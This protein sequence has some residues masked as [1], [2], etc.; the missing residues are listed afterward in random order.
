MYT[1][2]GWESAM[3]ALVTLLATRGIPLLLLCAATLGAQTDGNAITGF[4]PQAT[5]QQ[6]DLETQFDKILDRGDL[7]QWMHRIT[8]KPHHV[9]SPGSK[10]V[11]EFIA[12]LFKSWGY[13]TRID[14]Y[15][16]LF[17]TPKTRVV[18]MVAPTQYKAT[19]EE[20][21]VE[22]DATTKIREGSL[23][24]YNAYSG[25][26][27]V[28]GELVYVNYGI[29]D[30]YKKL[31][32]M[33]IDVKGKI[34]IAR[35]GGSWRGIKPKVA[36]ENGAIA[37]LIYSDPR[38][39]GYYAGDA[40]P[41]GGYRPRYGA[42]RGSVVDM[43]TYPGDPLTPGEAATDAARNPDPRMAATVM[44]IPV[45][46][47]SWGDAEPLLKALGGRVVPTSWRGALPFT[48]HVGPGPAKVHMKLEFDW[49][50]VP[51]YNV[52]ATMRGSQEPDQWVLR[53]NHHDAW[54]FGATDPVSGLV[55]LLEEARGLSALAKTGWKPRRTIMFLAWDGEEPGLLGS[56]EW[57]EAHAGE[58]REHAVAYLNTDGIGRGFV[59]LSGT[60]TLST[61]AA[62]AA[63][64]V[65]DPETGVDT[66]KRQL[67]RQSVHGEKEEFQLEPVGSGSD[68]TVFVDHLGIPVLNFGFGG[69]EDYGVY[70]SI[71]DSYDDFT[72]FV[73]PGFE[74]TL[75][76]AQLGGRMILRLAD[77]DL[78]PVSMGSLA[79]AV[80]QWTGEV[81][82]LADDM[83]EQTKKQNELIRTGA[84]K[85]AANPRKTYVPPEPEE[86]VPFLNFAPLEN[87]LVRLDAAASSVG[88]LD[89]ASLSPDQRTALDQKL[90]QAE[91]KLT[92][93]DGLPKRP[94][95]RHMLYA[96]GYY[97]GYGVKTLPG[98]RE[99][100]EQ[101][102]WAEAETQIGRLAETLNG[103]SGWL[104]NAVRF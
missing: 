7:E 36:A 77:A 18:E 71:Y 51:A 75:A 19:L 38:D 34:V 9:G 37:C 95:F 6:R 79:E 72:R 42:Q 86:E 12:G 29:P 90:I 85:L 14:T 63:R 82:K 103:F 46:P 92:R 61:L 56:T 27:D 31:R 2:V 55:A 49:K 50:L 87:A 96:P 62:E 52:V 60:P 64:D 17:P 53:G 23:P 20:P 65:T 44:K 99:A 10:E 22:G 70:H 98:V 8:A 11:A 74:Y 32:E 43:P 1:A 58:L 57:A 54:N 69:E 39:D 88:S 84:L 68:Y 81:R 25:D 100:I 13:D 93:D 3:K 101:R 66:M 33:G 5:G 59:N 67:A 21:P 35:Y 73:D 104:E 89:T 94:W 78:T 28:T 47:L 91:R 30:D 15:Y 80:R 4:A 45:L 41:D 76:T 16:P 24:V 48:Y 83:R 26:G 102:Q 97:T 40:Y